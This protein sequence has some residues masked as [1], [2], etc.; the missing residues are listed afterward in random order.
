MRFITLT[1]SV[2]LAKVT[3]ELDTLQLDVAPLCSAEIKCLL[4]PYMVCLTWFKCCSYYIA[5]K[6]VAN[7]DD[8]KIEVSTR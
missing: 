2:L 8:V 7:M 5:I 4:L 1:G 3:A 6:T